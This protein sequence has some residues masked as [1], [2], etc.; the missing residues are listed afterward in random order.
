[1]TLDIML[2]IQN[3]TVLVVVFFIPACESIIAVL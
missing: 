3:I 1:M 2:M